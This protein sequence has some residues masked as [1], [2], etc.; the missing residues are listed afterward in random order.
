MT[1]IDVSAVRGHR[2]VR[3][4]GSRTGRH[5]SPAAAAGH[6]PGTGTT[7]PARPPEVSA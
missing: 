3:P 5:G 1:G 6:H 7:I 2:R 4:S